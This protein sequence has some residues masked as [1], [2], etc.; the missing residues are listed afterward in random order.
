[1]QTIP[2]EYESKQIRVLQD[3]QGEPWWESLMFATFWG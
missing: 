2:F 3:A 1:M